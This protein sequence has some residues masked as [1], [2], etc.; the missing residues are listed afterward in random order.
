MDTPALTREEAA[1]G[2][3]SVEEPKPPKGY[4]FDPSFPLEN[5]VCAVTGLRYQRYG[6]IRIDRQRRREKMKI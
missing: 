5:G 4:V 1:E 6:L 2:A 3:L